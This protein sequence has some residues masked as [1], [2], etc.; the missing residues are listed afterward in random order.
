MRLLDRLARLP[1]ALWL[2]A[3]L[4][5]VAGLAAAVLDVRPVVRADLLASQVAHAHSAAPLIESSFAV[6]ALAGTTAAL[7]LSA[8]A[9]VTLAVLRHWRGALTLALSVAA[10]QLVVDLL[11]LAVERPRPA[12]NDV[13]A[14]ASGYSFPSAHS[15]TSV[16]VYATLAFLAARACCG[17]RRVLVIAAGAVLVSAVGLSRVYLGA[18]YPTDVLAGWLTGGVLV[19]A[20]WLVASRLAPARAP[21]TA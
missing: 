21:A 14:G 12:A 11:K 15:A 8:V 7:A 18:H 19:L 16:A 1:Y 3:M 5:V 9:I 4:T 6:S 10:T 20:S 17:G 2:G 13:A